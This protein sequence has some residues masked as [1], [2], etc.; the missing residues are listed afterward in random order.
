MI[1]LNVCMGCGVCV[2]VCYVENN[3]LV[4]GKVEMCKSC[5]MYWLWIDRYYFS[6]EFFF[7]D[8]VKKDNILGLGSFFLEF[9]EME[10][11]VDNL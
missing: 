6:E 5:D 3:V 4:V 7:D 1:D 8:V 9:R 11:F 2:V 10:N